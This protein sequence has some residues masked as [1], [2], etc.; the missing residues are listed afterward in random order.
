[1]RQSLVTESGTEVGCDHGDMG[2]LKNVGMTAR[3]IDNG[4]PVTEQCAPAQVR[5]DQQ[6]AKRC[7]VPAMLRG[8]KYDG[9]HP[10]AWVWFVMPGCRQIDFAHGKRRKPFG[11]RLS[12]GKSTEAKQLEEQASAQAFGLIKHLV[13]C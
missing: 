1:M 13:A 10:F 11:P 8:A 4:D 7:L 2:L 12:V 5:I 3:C 6:I 9:M